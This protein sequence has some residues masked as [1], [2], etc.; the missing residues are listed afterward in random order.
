M[1]SL[2]L[3]LQAGLIIHLPQIYI[4]FMLE[5]LTRL[6]EEDGLLAVKTLTDGY[7]KL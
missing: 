7:T 6:K 1:E 2:N 3:K 5:S 4:M